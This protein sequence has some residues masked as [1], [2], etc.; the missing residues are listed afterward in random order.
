[1]AG[2]GTAALPGLPANA[3]CPPAALPAGQE[4]GVRLRER[5]FGAGSGKKQGLGGAGMPRGHHAVTSLADSE[6]NKPKY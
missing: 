5:H 1:M 3:G 4:V 2:T 6:R